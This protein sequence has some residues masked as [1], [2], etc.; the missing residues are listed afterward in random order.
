MN[1]LFSFLVFVF[2]SFF[3]TFNAK[4][5]KLKTTVLRLCDI[6]LPKSTSFYVASNGTVILISS[7]SNLKMSFSFSVYMRWRRLTIHLIS[8]TGGRKKCIII[9]TMINGWKKETLASIKTTPK[10]IILP[11]KLAKRYRMSSIHLR[12]KT[13]KHTRTLHVQG[14]SKISNVIRITTDLRYIFDAS[15]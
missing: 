1:L 6:W 4:L 7:L 13:Q 14:D 11:C 5:T 10:L 3:N 8:L 9:K 15:I 2:F 12:R